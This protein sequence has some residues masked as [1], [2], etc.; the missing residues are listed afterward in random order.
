M[1]PNVP[2]RTSVRAGIVAMGLLALFAW[3]TLPQ[4]P[5]DALLAAEP[6]NDADGTPNLANADA[7]LR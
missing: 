4:A 7:S 2:T 1:N 5:L 3:A 6:A